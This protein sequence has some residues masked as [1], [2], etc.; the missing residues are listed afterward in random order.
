MGHQTL[1]P[2]EPA[3]GDRCH[4][5]TFC[6]GPFEGG[7]SKSTPT[8]QPSKVMTQF[9]SAK[10]SGHYLKMNGLQV[11]QEKGWERTGTVGPLDNRL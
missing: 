2:D 10:K 9:K 7:Q 5:L 4:R 8:Q 11:S 3:G 6:S 1:S